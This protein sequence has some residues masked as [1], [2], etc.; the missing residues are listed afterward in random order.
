VTVGKDEYEVIRRATIAASPQVVFDLIVDFHRWIE[1]SPWE[2]LDPALQRTFSGPESGVGAVY[3]WSGN[4]KAGQG[5]MEVT[6]ADAPSLVVVALQFIKPF[7]SKST[8]R[9]E[10]E[11]SGDSTNVTWRM[12]GQ[13]TFVTKVMGIFTSMDKMIGPDFEKGLKKLDGA[14]QAEGSPPPPGS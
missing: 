14:A 5:R 10:L 2:E 3:E 1:W 4:R 6:E 13:K 9:F 8:V 11:G 12:I 7:K